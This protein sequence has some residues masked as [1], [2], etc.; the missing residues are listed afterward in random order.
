MKILYLEKRYVFNVKLRMKKRI[1]KGWNIF[2]IQKSKIFWFKA[3]G[4]SPCSE[5]YVWY[6]LWSKQS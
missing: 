1:Q 6:C 4:S 5:I 2:V 3:V